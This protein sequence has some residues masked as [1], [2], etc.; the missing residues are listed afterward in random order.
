[1]LTLFYYE[2]RVIASWAEKENVDER[3]RLEYRRHVC[4]RDVQIYN[5]DYRHLAS[6]GWGNILDDS[7]LYCFRLGGNT[8]YLFFTKIT[9]IFA[10]E[11][12]EYLYAAEERTN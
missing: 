2:R 4:S 9:K 10:Q 6:T 8:Q 3:R 5:L 7:L 1:M 12:Y 11:T